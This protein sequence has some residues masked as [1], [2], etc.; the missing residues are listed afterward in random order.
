MIRRP[1]RSTLFP[2]TTLSRSAHFPPGQAPVSR[3][4][5]YQPQHRRIERIGEIG[6]GGDVAAC[7][8][9]VFGEVIRADREENGIERLEE[10]KSTPPNS[11][12]RSNSVCRLL[13]ER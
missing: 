4:I 10:R 13:L 9:D 2:S 12:Y 3:N 11:N 5:R 1:P 6:H 7:G 8:G